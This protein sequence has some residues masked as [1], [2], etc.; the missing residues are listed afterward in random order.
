MHMEE[1]VLESVNS[2]LLQLV[3]SLHSVYEKA[4]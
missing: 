4:E 2:F 1:N 3:C